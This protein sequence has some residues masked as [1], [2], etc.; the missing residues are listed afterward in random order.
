MDLR[1]VMFKIV[2]PANDA[3]RSIIAGGNVEVISVDLQLSPKSMVRNSINTI[4]MEKGSLSLT[5]Y[6]T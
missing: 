4:A 2:E 5:A 1:I 6:F 3:I